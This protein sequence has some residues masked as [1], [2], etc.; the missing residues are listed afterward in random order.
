M[1]TKRGI[2]LVELSVVL[3]IITLLLTG[4]LYSLVI[5][6]NIL[7]TQNTDR[8]LG[9]IKEALLGYA[10]INHRLPCR[11]TDLKGISSSMPCDDKEGF[12]PW[13][14]LGTTPTDAWGQPFRYCLNNS[15]LATTEQHVFTTGV[16]R[17]VVFSYG[18]DRRPNDQ[19]ATS[20][21]HYQQMTYR[22]LMTSNYFDDQLIY[23]SEHTLVNYLVMVKTQ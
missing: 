2:T 13:L 23:L 15:L 1:K 20:T 18:K 8:M 11:A 4:L 7:N 14:E 9:E 22:P 16:I 21:G 19:N 3:L 12:L 5:Q 6:M 17:A 10:A